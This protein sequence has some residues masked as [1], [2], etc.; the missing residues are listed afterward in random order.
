MH[1]PGR[2][3]LSHNNWKQIRKSIKMSF[4]CDEK[5]ILVFLRFCWLSNKRFSMLH[6]ADSEILI[7]IHQLKAK[8]CCFFF[9]FCATILLSL[10]SL[11]QKVFFLSFFFSFLKWYQETCIDLFHCWARSGKKWCLIKGSSLL[12]AQQWEKKILKK[13]IQFFLLHLCAI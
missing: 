11:C 13:K 1:E 7:N 12:A 10:F 6:S 5:K 8:S 4:H 2:D 9:F 3:V